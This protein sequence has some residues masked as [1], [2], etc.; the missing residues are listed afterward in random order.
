MNNKY[1]NLIFKNDII[2]LST[3]PFHND[4]LYI[5]RYCPESFPVHLAIH[6]ISEANNEFEYTALHSHEMHELNII[7]GDESGLE[8]LVKLGDETYTVSS[9]FSIWIPGG[10]MHSTNVIR[11]SGYYIVVRFNNIPPEFDGLKTPQV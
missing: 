6:K 7:L 4:V 3:M 8:Y 10:L 9:N 11:G 5:E 2:P 1:S